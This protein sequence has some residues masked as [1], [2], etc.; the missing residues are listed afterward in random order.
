MQFDEELK[1]FSEAL[2]RKSHH[3]CKPHLGC[4]T[5]NECQR[6]KVRFDVISV[7][8]QLCEIT[9][10]IRLGLSNSAIVRHTKLLMILD[11]I[12]DRFASTSLE[13]FVLVSDSNSEIRYHTSVT[14][15]DSRIL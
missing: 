3:S 15:R 5:G 11:L 6:E 12:G 1:S 2:R 4:G 14:G 8:D 9:A 13:E 7:G 10:A